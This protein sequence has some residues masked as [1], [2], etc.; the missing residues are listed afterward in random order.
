MILTEDLWNWL[1]QLSLEEL[2]TLLLWIPFLVYRKIYNANFTYCDLRN[3]LAPLQVDQRG[4]R[5]RQRRPLPQDPHPEAE[6]RH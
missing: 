3:R 4:R 6:Q 5:V 1:D 2:F